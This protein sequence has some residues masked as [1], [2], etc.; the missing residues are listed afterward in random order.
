MKKLLILTVGIVIFCLTG[1]RFYETI[2]TFEFRQPSENIV[3]IEI[4]KKEYDSINTDTPL[5]LLKTFDESEYSKV[6]E[7]I[8]ALD[9][10]RNTLDPPTGFGVCV[11]RI[12]YEDGAQEII[13]NYSKGY[14]LPNGELCE[15]FYQLD[16]E[17]FY[18]LVS[19]LLGEEI[20]DY[21]LG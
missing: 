2:E 1:C 21:T 3:C 11:F 16:R 20:T 12:T 13:G 10:W 19:E 6:I 15:D 17:Q 8:P 9:G 14:I 5:I 18:S 4:L 7:G